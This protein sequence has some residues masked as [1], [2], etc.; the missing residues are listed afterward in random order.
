ME[1]K[2]SYAKKLYEEKVSEV[3]QD[4][5]YY[6]ERF[7]VVRYIE[8]FVKLFYLCSELPEFDI[9]EFIQSVFMDGWNSSVHYYGLD[10]DNSYDVYYDEDEE[11]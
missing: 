11:K 8:D 1:T 5:R 2:N 6:L 4:E 3:I 10:E 9:K 7:D